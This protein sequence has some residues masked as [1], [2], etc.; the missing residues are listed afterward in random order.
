V[1][2]HVER[3]TPGQRDKQN[4]A[5][6]KETSKTQPRPKRQAKHSQGQR[7]KQDKATSKNKAHRDLRFQLTLACLVIA[8]KLLQLGFVLSFVLLSQVRPCSSVSASEVSKRA[9]ARATATTAR[10][11]RNTAREQRPEKHRAP[12]AAQADRNAKGH[13]HEA[14]A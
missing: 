12:P 13:A 8:L 5:K 2:S 9:R 11:Q 14:T 6:A 10:E 7:D 3:Q 1:C 4:T